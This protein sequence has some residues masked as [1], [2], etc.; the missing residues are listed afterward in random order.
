MRIF[1]IYLLYNFPICIYITYSNV[2]YNLHVVHCIPST[3]KESEREVAQSCPTLSNPMDCSPPGSSVHGIFQA[4]VLEWGAI[5]FS[6]ES[7][8]SRD[9]TRIS[10]IVGRR[11][12]V[13]ATI[14]KLEFSNFWPPSSNSSSPYFPCLLTTNLIFFYNFGHFFNSTCEWVYTVF[15]F[16]CLTYFI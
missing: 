13:W 2:N 12:T 9:W 15:V 16:I 11:F 3:W 8:Q 6:R 1:R 4:R 10:R 5:S 14:L 7:S